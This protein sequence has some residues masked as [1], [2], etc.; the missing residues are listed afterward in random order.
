MA[1]VLALFGVAG[2]VETTSQTSTVS[3]ASVFQ[4]IEIFDIAMSWSFARLI[5]R[6]C[7]KDFQFNQKA[8]DSTIRRLAE[9]NPGIAASSEAQIKAVMDSPG[10]E[11]RID[12]ATSAFFKRHKIDSAEP[13]QWC[14]AGRSEKANKTA[15]GEFLIAT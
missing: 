13:P 3:A 14:A 7:P 15:V 4:S 10:M 1:G 5:A 2:C 8:S 11:A 6:Q 9:A 12:K